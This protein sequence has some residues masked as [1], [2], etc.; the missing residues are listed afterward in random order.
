MVCRASKKG[1]ELKEW[2]KIKFFRIRKG[3]SHLHRKQTALKAC[4]MVS[5]SVLQR[6]GYHKTCRRKRPT[7]CC[8]NVHVHVLFIQSFS[9]WHCS[10]THCCLENMQ[11]SS[12][13]HQL[14]HRALQIHLNRSLPFEH[15]G[16]HTYRRKVFEENVVQCLKL[17]ASLVT[18]LLATAAAEMWEWDEICIQSTSSAVH[19]TYI[20]SCSFLK[21]WGKTT[22]RCF[23]I[24]WAFGNTQ[25]K[26][27]P[28]PQ[29][30]ISSSS[31]IFIPRV[32]QRSTSAKRSAFEGSLWLSLLLC[33]IPQERTWTHSL[34]QLSRPIDCCN[35]TVGV[36]T[37][38]MRMRFP[39]SLTHAGWKL[40][41]M[42]A[43][44][45][46]RWCQ[47]SKA[48]QCQS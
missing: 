42:P 23:S 5:L 44:S 35:Q 10:Q 30:L 33:P 48:K 37:G 1:R 31:L 43:W 8:L 41:F 24:L 11:K 32:L 16:T 3:L 21:K 13:N 2:I 6:A 47:G 46:S 17:C 25:A 19:Q 36:Q 27:Q 14:H 4:S 15:N 39:S 29:W 18:R 20:Y 28:R 38:C 45:H 7:L 12:A 26:T 22:H 34:L 40:T 9:F